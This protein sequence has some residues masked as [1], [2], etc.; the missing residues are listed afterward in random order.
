MR[1][2][3]DEGPRSQQRTNAAL[4]IKGLASRVRDHSR[5]A[6]VAHRTLPED[7]TPFVGLVNV[8]TRALVELAEERREP[9]WLKLVW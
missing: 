9:R 7:A 8:G 6:P 2:R 4:G 1:V 5:G 3:L